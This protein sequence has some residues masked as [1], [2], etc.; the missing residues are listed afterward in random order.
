MWM[1][2]HTLAINIRTQLWKLFPQKHNILRWYNYSGAVHFLKEH[3]SPVCIKK[4]V[5]FQNQR[6]IAQISTKFYAARVQLHKCPCAENR[7]GRKNR[8][9]YLE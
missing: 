5:N 2:T 6:C 7:R 4:K 1:S 9:V 8:D 3:I